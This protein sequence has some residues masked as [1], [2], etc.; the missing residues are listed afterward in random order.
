MKPVV[1]AAIGVVLG[2][3]ALSA[4][5]LL[6]RGTA[7]FR[8]T[9][10]TALVVPD[11]TQGVGVVLVTRPEGAPRG[12]TIPYLFAAMTFDP[13]TAGQWADSAKALA[14]QG[15]AG[16][17]PPLTL[18]SRDSSLLVLAWDRAVT[19]QHTRSV[20]AYYP[21]PSPDGNTSLNIEVDSADVL[22]FLDSLRA[23]SGVS[24][25]DPHAPPPDSTV[26]AA[27]AVGE[28][29]EIVSAPPVEYP[30]YLRQQR[31]QGVVIVQAIV[32][33][34]GWV[35]PL[36]LKVKSASNPGFI[37][38]AK[39]VVLKSRFRPARLNGHLVRVLIQVPVNFTLNHR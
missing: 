7:A 24:R 20:L 18:V 5:E 22:A 15:A 38:P 13:V 17:T 3:G 23:K 8:W 6:P 26:L 28:K 4:Q 25:Y 32:D 33:T 16:A 9:T 30:E 11:S 21:P 14:A 12:A 39:A 34:T 31:E 29:P 35:E 1:A 19:K 36:S 37:P 10:V 27:R 2:H